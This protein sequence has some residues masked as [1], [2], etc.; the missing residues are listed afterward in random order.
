MLRATELRSSFNGGD[1]FTVSNARLSYAKGERKF[2]ISSTKASIARAQFD[3]NGGRAT[4]W[5]V[6]V[7]AKHQWLVLL[8]G[9]GAD[10]SL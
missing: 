6:S 10:C 9:R 4:V 1:N 5:Y 3:V 8:P 7:V 2:R